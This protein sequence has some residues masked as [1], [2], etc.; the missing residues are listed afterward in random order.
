VVIN[1]EAVGLRSEFQ[2]ALPLA[3]SQISISAASPVP[4]Y[5]Q[6]CR[7]LRIAISAGDLPAGTLLPTSREL[8]QALDVG[9][10][11]V[12]SAYSRL[13][14]EGFV[15][16]KFRRG[17]R[18]ATPLQ[19]TPLQATAP[20]A[21]SQTS[22]LHVSH[23]ELVA[24]EEQTEPL[25][26]IGF[27]GR[28]TLETPGQAENESLFAINAPDPALHPRA[29]LQKLI[30][31][32]FGRTHFGASDVQN[33]WRRF[34][35]AICDHFR[36][37]RGVVCEP[38]QVI[39]VTGMCAALDLA[40]RLMLDPGHAVLVEDPAPV[41]VRAAFHSAGARLFPLPSDASGADPARSKS[42]PPRLIYVSPSVSFPSGAQMPAPRRAA[43]LQSAR[44]CAA[45]IFE[46]DGYAELLYTGSPLGAI[47]GQDL[48]GRVLYYASLKNMLGPHICVGAFVV[49]AHLADAFSRI[50]LQAGCTPEAWILA[51]IAEFVETGQYAMHAKKMRAAYA[52]RLKLVVQTCRTLLPE[53][54]I[55]EPHGGIHLTLNL[56][57]HVS[58]YEVAAVA[59]HGVPMAPLARFSLRKQPANVLVIGFGATPERSI[60]PGI[61]RL[62]AI[63]RQTPP[64]H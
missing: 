45:A 3:I 56:P 35:T 27:A 34:Q 11:T 18:V 38:G 40:A 5:E 16:A 58:A 26:D 12:V 9:R 53:A 15:V 47:Q 55:G 22:A 50:A 62:A 54:Q 4:I 36:Q 13:V 1:I 41:E 14:A 24:D 59:D 19:A 52:Q 23:S 7:A 2:S 17:T 49:P 6:I 44:A 33:D 21:A 31:D 32:A 28:R 42:P 57:V 43:L 37:A 46:F 30:A 64:F 25:P 61:R 63:V 51:A 29:A 20:Q 48:D 10:N 60:E 8:A 39:P